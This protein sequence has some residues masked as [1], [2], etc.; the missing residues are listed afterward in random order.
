MLDRL[1]PAFAGAAGGSLQ[2][3]VHRPQN[4]PDMA[5]MVPHPG[6]PLDH[7]GHARQRPQ[8]GAEAVGA[9]PLAQSPVDLL[10]VGAV[11]LR[12]APRSARPAQRRH[13]ALSPLSVP[14]RDALAADLDGASDRGQ[15]RAVAEQSRGLHAPPF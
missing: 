8:I 15:N 12:L 11:Q 1:V 14:A 9:R 2:G 4:L 6:Q 13:A 7:R 5:G 10:E 3:P